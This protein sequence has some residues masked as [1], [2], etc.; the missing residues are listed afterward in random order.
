MTP[1]N[2]SRV[3]VS[4]NSAVRLTL[5]AAVVSVAACLWWAWC[6]FPQ[7]AW[8]EVRLA[9]AFALR[10]GINPYPAEGGGP[11]STWIYGPV[12]LV[13]NLPATFAPTA[14]TALQTAGLINF[15]VVI[16]P[17]A[18]VFFGSLELRARGILTCGLALALGVLL[19]PP[20]NLV[21][22]VADHAAIAFGLL[23]CWR[24]TRFPSLDQ[25]Q[26]AIAAFLCAVAIWS[27]QITVFLFLG[28]FAY[29]MFARNRNTALAYAA[30]SAAFCGLGAMAAAAAFGFANLWFNLVTIP[31]HLPWAD[32]P[33]RLASRP[34]ALVAHVALPGV[35]L[36][37]LWRCKRWP[38]AS[39]ESGRFFQLTAAVFCAMLPVGL[40]AYC[41]IGGDTNLLHSWSYLMPGLLLVWLSGHSGISAT[42]RHLLI[43]TAA[44]LVLQW[45][46][47]TTLPTRPQTSHFIMARQVTT[48]FPD[49]VWF[50]QNPVITFYASGQLWHSEDGIV[51]RHLAGFDLHGLDFQQHLPPRLKAVCYPIFTKTHAVMSLLPGFSRNT[52][53]PYWTLLTQPEATIPARE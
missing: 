53:L 2:S 15:L 29:L 42:P 48:A 6:H 35:A 41:K 51:T 24:L 34:W 30:W 36:F 4:W 18:L 22:Q 33:A 28:Q 20:P 8:N 17:L 37:I 25:V 32:I 13:V 39:H 47:L 38:Q 31:S 1:T 10:H 16:G 49:T 40:V 44:A 7:L 45:P 14:Q 23:S 11:L 46:R 43:V 9:P 5:M 12:G 27:K 52:E 21:L 50:P 19:V 26:L 3:A